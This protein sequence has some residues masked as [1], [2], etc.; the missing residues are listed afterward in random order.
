SC[1]TVHRPMSIYLPVWSHRC[2]PLKVTPCCSFSPKT[3]Q[4]IPLRWSDRLVYHVFLRRWLVGAIGLG[5][6]MAFM[7][8][9]VTLSP[10]T[11]DEVVKEWAVTKPI[12]TVLAPCLIAAGN[13]FVSFPCAPLPRAPGA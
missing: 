12:M 13:C 6:F 2:S 4:A 5:V 1:D 3:Y 10:P 9:L 11:K 8:A 7:V